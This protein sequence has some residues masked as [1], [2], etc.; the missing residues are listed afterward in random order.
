MALLF[1]HGGSARSAMTITKLKFTSGK[2][3]A[4]RNAGERES[5]SSNQRRRRAT[6]WQTFFRESPANG[7]RQGTATF[8]HPNSKVAAIPKFGGCVAEGMNGRR[9]LTPEP[10]AGIVRI[11]PQNK[12]GSNSGYTLNCCPSFQ[13]HD[14]DISSMASNAMSWFLR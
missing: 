5:A 14:C 2:T 10:R 13:M 12:H 11:A 4:A 7:T 9:L 3:A 6:R 1:G 8:A